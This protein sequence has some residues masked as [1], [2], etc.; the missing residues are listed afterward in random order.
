[1][2][3]YRLKPGQETIDIVDGDHAGKRF[4]RG[5]TYSDIPGNEK[6]R[7]EKIEPPKAAKKTE[8]PEPVAAPTGASDPKRFGLEAEPEIDEKTGYKIVKR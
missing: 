4:E 3:Q 8:K 6:H 5:K 7:F 1:M 2:A